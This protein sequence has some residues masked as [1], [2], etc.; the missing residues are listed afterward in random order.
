MSNENGSLSPSGTPLPETSHPKG[1]SIEKISTFEKQIKL[2]SFNTLEK[3]EY[4]VKNNQRNIPAWLELI[5]RVQFKGSVEE[6]RKVYERFLKI[7]PN[8]GDV[9][10]NYINFELSKGE[11]SNAE[12]LYERCLTR[13]SNLNLWKSYITYVRKKN[14]IITGGQEARQV[15]IQSYDIALRNIGIDLESGSV[16]EDY[17][18]FVDEW[19][20]ISK[21]EEQQKLELKRKTFKQC[22]VTPSHK[23]EDLWSLYTMFENEI[24]P[25]YA[26]KQISDISPQY[27]LARTWYKEFTNLTKS[28]V[29]HSNGDEKTVVKSHKIWINLEKQ[30]KLRLTNR[31]LLNT[32]IEFSFVKTLQKFPFYP[33]IWF[34]YAQFKLSEDLNLPITLPTTT[35]T[36]VSS[37]GKVTG[38][39][40]ENYDTGIKILTESLSCCP[41]S[42]L[43]TYLL[44]E[45]Y[46]LKNNQ[47]LI[48]TTFNK[49]VDQLINQYEQLVLDEE[50]LHKQLSKPLQ[51]QNVG[52]DNS[53]G[54]KRSSKDK[55]G[56]GSD[57]G[58]DHDDNDENNDEDEDDEDEDDNGDENNDLDTEI[59]NDPNAYTTREAQRQNG[60]YLSNVELNKLKLERLITTVYINYIK[61]SKRSIKKA[62][63]RTIF[64][65]ARKRFKNLTWHI[66]YEEALFEYNTSSNQQGG[67]KIALK[68]FDTGMK[69]L[70]LHDHK[71]YPFLI[72][73]FKFLILINDYT[74][75]KSLFEISI[76]NLTSNV[77]LGNGNNPYAQYS[78]SY[79]DIHHGIFPYDQATITKRQN[80]ESKQRNKTLKKLFKYFLRYELY[81][82]NILSIHTLQNRYKEIFPNDSQLY[83]FSQVFKEYDGLNMIKEFEIN[84]NSNDLFNAWNNY[85][86]NVNNLLYQNEVDYLLDSAGQ[87]EINNKIKQE[88][89]LENYNSDTDDDEVVNN[90][91]L[92]NYGFK[93]KSSI[94]QNSQSNMSNNNKALKKS[95]VGARNIVK[96]FRNES[97]AD[98]GAVVTENDDYDP[99]NIE[100]SVP[101]VNEVP[102]VNFNQY[103]APVINEFVGQNIVVDESKPFVSDSIYNLLRVLP[104]SNSFDKKIFDSTKL[105]NLLRELSLPQGSG[106]GVA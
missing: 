41:N 42:T 52:K 98:A 32:R 22:I 94:L 2:L 68:I 35:T 85:N 81:N 31:K 6:V 99:S 9:Y 59:H 19:N 89:L 82:G 26:R 65:D 48:T 37:A 78:T 1:T 10:L 77:G 67:I 88:H 83:I 11:V 21:W 73:Y 14:D 18:K 44:A 74:N 86:T 96:R 20:P 90:D 40:E 97:D 71:N 62:T 66:Y 43:L 80:Y 103:N 106:P 17:L 72:E 92:A 30:N 36:D 34:D 64:K 79:G 95:N 69:N 4:T 46:E 84:T 3:L 100:S 102:S 27:M 53:H 76:K 91:D 105:V 70:E 47:A 25:S 104:S 39:R 75:I 58:H 33:E 55:N 29:A 24:N 16:W 38:Y 7:F 61:V 28:I 60:F 54:M 63:A 101:S 93:T 13:T 49:L 23:L 50:Y 87:N 5:S 45:L 8:N 15:V 57:N 56:N 12:S 51:G